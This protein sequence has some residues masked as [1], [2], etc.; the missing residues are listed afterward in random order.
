MKHYQPY[1]IVDQSPWPLLTGMCVLMTV[2]GL[3]A[4]FHLN[5]P[6]LFFASL[7]LLIGCVWRWA[8]D[9]CDESS[10]GFHTKPVQSNMI[11]GFIMF[12]LSEIALFASFFWAFFTS[13]LVPTPEIGLTWP[14]QGIHIPS[15]SG[16]PL[17]GTL[18]LLSSGAFLT[19]SHHAMTTGQDTD[20]TQG[21]I[22]CLILGEGFAVLQASEYA[23]AQFSIADSA[24]G[25]CFFMLTGL[26]GSHVLIGLSLLEICL[27]RHLKGQFATNHHLGFETSAWYWHFVDV[28]WL[29]VFTFIYC[30]GC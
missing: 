10:L 19:W 29:F 4:M 2:S 9:I 30:W 26:H 3:I 28:V 7:L 15:P 27:V 24:L 13:A 20:V 16:A 21:L 18:L 23:C 22:W 17:L 6:L 14:P 12:I 5:S 25:S 11:T 8:I 1:H